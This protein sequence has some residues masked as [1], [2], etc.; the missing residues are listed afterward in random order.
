[1]TILAS[2][3]FNQSTKRDLEQEYELHAIAWAES[4]L[5]DLPD[6]LTN[7]D[8]GAMRVELVNKAMRRWAS[9]ARQ[10]QQ[11]RV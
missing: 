2:D 11:G 9:Q 3:A 8:I 5:T 6:D 4:Q 1:M 10:C 7:E